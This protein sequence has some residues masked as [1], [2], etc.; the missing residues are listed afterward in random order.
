MGTSTSY[1]APPTWGDLKGDVTRA[2]GEGPLTPNRA[3]QLIQSFIAHNGGAQA[4]SGRTGTGGTVAQGRA[5]RSIA[6]RVGGF[7]SDVARLG[8]DGALQSSGLADLIGRPAREI[9]SGLLDRLGGE[10]STIDEVDARM[11]LSRLQDK[12]FGDAKT[13]EELEQL[14]SQQGDQV[15]ILLQDFFGFYLFEVFCRVFFERLIRKHGDTRAY[16]FLG[17]IE[18][19]IR[20]TL[21]NR[22][23]R[24]DVKRLGWNGTEG[25]ALISDIMETT[26]RVFGG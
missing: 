5:A 20:S 6:G 21:T 3:G 9:L 14:L 11:A 24:Y 18:D 23:M 25:E 19:F 13:P 17:E 1:S 12:Y 26:L 4:I 7:I 8:L 2:A 15:D 22:S 16:S 10:S